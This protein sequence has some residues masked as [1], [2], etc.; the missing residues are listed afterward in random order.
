MVGIVQFGI[1]NCVVHCTELCSGFLMRFGQ[2][3]G[4]HFPAICCK[5]RQNKPKQTN[6][7]L[8]CFVVFPYSELFHYFW[9]KNCP[10]GQ[11]FGVSKILNKRYAAYLGCPVELSQK[12]RELHLQDQIQYSDHCYKYW[13]FFVTA[14][15]PMIVANKQDVPPMSNSRIHH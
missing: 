8:R 12:N 14:R 4:G 10:V 13:A 5:H 9:A 2:R 11:F 7:V 1:Q 6:K 15:I 3:A